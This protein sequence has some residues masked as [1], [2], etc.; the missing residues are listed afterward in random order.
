M[1]LVIDLD[2]GTTVFLK[3]YKAPMDED[4]STCWRRTPERILDWQLEWIEG[5]TENGYTLY[6]AVKHIIKIAAVAD[7]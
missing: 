4:E 7:L 1:T 3:K 6:I 2:N 5:V